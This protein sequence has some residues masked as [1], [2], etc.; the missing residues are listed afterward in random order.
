M[1]SSSYSDAMPD[2]I[3]IWS[4]DFTLATLTTNVHG[5]TEYEFTEQNTSLLRGVNRWR[6]LSQNEGNSSEPRPQGESP[7]L[8]VVSDDGTIYIV[9]T[10]D[11]ATRRLRIVD[12]DTL[13]FTELEGG[14][15][16]R[17]VTARL[18]RQ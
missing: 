13:V 4:G 12:A 3:G 11:R 6:V 15:E 9:S 7:V 5:H 18:T 10:A 16:I 2:L 17:T 14:E 8:A 1:S